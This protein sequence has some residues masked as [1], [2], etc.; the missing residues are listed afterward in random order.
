MLLRIRGIVIV[1]DDLKNAGK[2]PAENPRLIATIIN[3]IGTEII[4]AAKQDIIIP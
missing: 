2:N 1:R 3:A 4:I